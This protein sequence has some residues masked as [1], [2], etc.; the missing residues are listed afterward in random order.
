SKG[1]S[2]VRLFL[3]A[4]VAAASL[5]A[6]NAWADRANDTLVFS[7]TEEIATFDQYYNTDRIGIIMAHHIFDRLIW[8]NPDTN[9]LE[10]MLATSWEWIDD[11]TLE[12]ELRE[13]V[14][15]HDGESFEAE[16]VVYT[17]GH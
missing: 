7:D 2:A 16:D 1:E 4:G 11:T 3:L 9:E 8:R 17:I 5:A 14:T 12:F 10:P 15:F 13:G 6:Q